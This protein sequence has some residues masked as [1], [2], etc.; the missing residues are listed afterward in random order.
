[1]KYLMWIFTTILPTIQIFTI[2]SEI[3]LL[4]KVPLTLLILDVLDR[5]IGNPPA[6]MFLTSGI[7]C[8]CSYGFFI[9]Q[10]LI[11][12]RFKLMHS[13]NDITPSMV[14]RTAFPKMVDYI[15]LLFSM[16]TPGALL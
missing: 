12:D 2:F 3:H 15:A 10:M 7:R 1:M 16:D 8:I 9:F 4:I 6:L 5:W 14:Y 13:L 11:D